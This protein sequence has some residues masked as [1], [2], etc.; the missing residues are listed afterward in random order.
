MIKVNVHFNQNGK[1][2]EETVEDAFVASSEP[3]Y[4]GLA[5]NPSPGLWEFL[6]SGKR[7]AIEVENKLS[8][9]KVEFSIDVGENTLFFLSPLSD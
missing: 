3:F 4:I 2:N 9:Y 8:N 7:P 1:V 6:K 5:L